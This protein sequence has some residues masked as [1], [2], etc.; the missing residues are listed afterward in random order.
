MPASTDRRRPVRPAVGFT[1][2]EVLVA[3]SIVAVTLGA[4]LQ[5]AGA[6]TRNAQRLGEVSEAQWCADNQLGAL[7]LTRQFP[8]VG[9]LGFECL[10]LGR[11]YAGKLIV[12]PTPNPNF[13][14]VDATI[15]D[16]QAVP[17]LT[18]STVIGRF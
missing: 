18:V 8:D 7:R 15:S 5:A 2:I 4:G 11:V 3:L 13:R 14:R 1:L 17:L 12:R 16:A 6:L 9:D 10:Q